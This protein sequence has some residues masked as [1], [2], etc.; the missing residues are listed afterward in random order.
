MEGLQC[1]KW[2][3]RFYDIELCFEMES[4]GQSFRGRGLRDWTV[5]CEDV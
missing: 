4:L 3:Q 5:G 2:Y 1:Y